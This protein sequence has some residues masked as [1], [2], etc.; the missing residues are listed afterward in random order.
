ML[1]Q[2]R[3][4]GPDVLLKL[5]VTIDD[6]L[7]RLQASLAPQYLPRAPRGGHPQLSAAEVLTILVRGAWRG[8]HGKAK[9]YY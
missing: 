4:S 7:K 1:M 2:E 5:F 3:V 6:L 9:L 8:L